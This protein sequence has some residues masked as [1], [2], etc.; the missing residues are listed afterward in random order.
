MGSTARL[1]VHWTHH[2]WPVT[3]TL[4]DA[5]AVVVVDVIAVIVID[6]IDVIAVIAVIVI[7]VIDVIDV[8]KNTQ[9]NR[10]LQMPK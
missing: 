1:P 4:T 9:C 3:E 10:P 5:V 8:L 7:D 2:N 6:V